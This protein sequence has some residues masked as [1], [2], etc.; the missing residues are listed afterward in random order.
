[1]AKRNH[2]PPTPPVVD[3]AAVIT[4]CF[5]AMPADIIINMKGAAEN[6]S[7]LDALFFSIEQEAQK[8]EPSSLRIETLAG[9]GRYL[10]EDFSNFYDCQHETFRDKL[11]EH[12][13]ISQPPA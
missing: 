5:G 6:F 7:W 12:G 1:M 9:M 10:S 8:P 2:I 11:Q 13:V 3:P 4:E